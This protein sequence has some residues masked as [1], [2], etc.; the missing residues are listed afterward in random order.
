MAIIQELSQH[1]IKESLQEL[2]RRAAPLAVTCHAGSTWFY[3]HSRVLQQTDG[4]LWLE[5]PSNAEGPVPT[6]EASMPL[7]MSFKV[8]HHKHVFNT[9]VEAVGHF[10][11]ASSGQVK[12]ISIAVPSR[13]QRIQR[14]AY[15]RV[16][17]PRSRSVL[18]TFWQGGMAASPPVKL[19][20]EAW[21]TN[22][23]AGGCQV[24]ASQHSLP[25]L[26][27]GELVGIRLDLGQ[28]YEPVLADAQLRHVEKDE[29]G[30]ALLG[31]QFVGLNDTAQG[32]DMLRRI[33]Q[34][35]LDFQRLAP[36]RQAESA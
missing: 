7:G 2:I 30:V 14:R 4:R 13:M 11:T 29:R 32:R 12:A 6:I 17:V 18:A 19:T 34:A 24:R 10:S 31:Y 3:S 21:V 16:E 1:Q 36:R 8:R 26:E 33:G 27:E 23:S 15:N 22:L 20:W 25:E 28:G 9:V 35:V 5:Y